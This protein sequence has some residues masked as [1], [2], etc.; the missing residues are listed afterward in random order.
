[1]LA[2]LRPV[3]PP[4]AHAR[5][6]RRGRAERGAAH[7]GRDAS[8]GDRHQGGHGRGHHAH[9]DGDREPR[10]SFTLNQSAEPVRKYTGGSWPALD[11][12]LGLRRPEQG[13]E[14]GHRHRRQHQRQGLP[15]VHG[16]HGDCPAHV[17]LRHDARTDR[18]AYTTGATPPSTSNVD[19][20]A[21]DTIADLALIP[22]NTADQIS[23]TNHS[24]G[25]TD[26]VVDCS[27]YFD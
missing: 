18:A 26:L 27:G 9:R 4:T 1:M 19:F 14:P 24:S 8:K 12:T 6:S 11:A 5:R 22:T 2:L 21:S 20:S 10:G 16:L 7:G 25:T 23:I 13:R 3:R 17:G 15:W